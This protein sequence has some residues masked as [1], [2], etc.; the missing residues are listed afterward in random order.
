MRLRTSVLR[1]SL[2]SRAL[3]CTKNGFAPTPL[4]QEELLRHRLLRTSLRASLRM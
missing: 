3:L 2:R 1:A 4:P